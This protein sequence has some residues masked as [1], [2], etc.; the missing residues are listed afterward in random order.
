M[1]KTFCVFLSAHNVEAMSVWET[2]KTSMPPHCLTASKVDCTLA[3]TLS[4]TCPHCSKAYFSCCL[5]PPPPPVSPPPSLSLYKCKLKPR[6]LATK[7]KCHGRFVRQAGQVRCPYLSVLWKGFWWQLARLHRIN[8]PG[9]NY[10]RQVRARGVSHALEQLE[11]PTRQLTKGLVPDLMG[12]R[13][14][15]RGKG[16]F[17][18][19]RSACPVPSICH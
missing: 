18:S 19:K 11:K 4:A 9:M 2:F 17:I 1:S 15:T 14:C 7:C 3:R 12:G 8:W 6:P 13:C 10:Q 5:C 16:I